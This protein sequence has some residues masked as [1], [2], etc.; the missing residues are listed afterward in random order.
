MSSELEALRSPPDKLATGN[1]CI[2]RSALGS[3][4][5][6]LGPWSAGSS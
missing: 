5:S 2:D 3:Q 4:R 6:D 1:A